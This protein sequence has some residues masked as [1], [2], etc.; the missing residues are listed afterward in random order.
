ML[1]SQE[2]RTAR[3]E[4]F[5][6]GETASYMGSS[7]PVFQSYD[8]STFRPTVPQED[9][10]GSHR[11]EKTFNSSVQNRKQKETKVPRAFFIN[12]PKRDPMRH[13]FERQGPVRK[14]KQAIE[15]VIIKK[16]ESAKK[17]VRWKDEDEIHHVEKLEYHRKDSGAGV[18]AC[19]CQIF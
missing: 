9:T 8:L 16:K 3:E 12:R 14:V 18:S 10:L 6:Q 19:T 11:L 2:K 1:N 7:H 17:V 4:G 15:E 5:S 13:Y